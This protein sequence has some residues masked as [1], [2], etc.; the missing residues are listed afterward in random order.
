[1]NS[2]KVMAKVGANIKKE[3]VQKTPVSFI[4]I[5]NKPHLNDIGVEYFI[6]MAKTFYLVTTNKN[7]PIFKYK[8][9]ENMEILYYEKE[10]D[11]IDLFNQLKCKYNI[12]KMT[13]QTGGTLNSIILRNN[14][15]DKL[16]VVVAPAL[17]GGKDTSTLIDGY[18]L[19]TFDDLKNIKVLKLVDIIRLDDSYINIKYDI[20]NQTKIIE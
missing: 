4:I 19:Q 16:S 7:H 18:S 2:G 9:T 3:N 15:I 6:K 8:E 10:I 13:L 20:I 5:D 14:L 11:F 17:V 12:E 1:M